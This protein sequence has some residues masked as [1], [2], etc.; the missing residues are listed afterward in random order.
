VY[1]DKDMGIN[2]REK[3]RQRICIIGAGIAGLSAAYDLS[4]WGYDVIILESLDEV[5][6]LASSLDVDG[7][8]IERFYHFISKY[9]REL[10]AFVQELELADKL[11]WEQCKTS[12]FYNGKLYRFNTP[13]DLLR[14]TPIPFDQRIRFGL[15]IIQ[16][17]FRR[18]WLTLDKLSAK[19]WLT[20]KVGQRAYDVIWDP[21]LR[22]KFGKYHE[23]VSAAWIWH[24][25]H[26]VATSRRRIWESEVFGYLD[27]GSETLIRTLV[28]CVQKLP[29]VELRINADVCRILTKN[30]HVAGVELTENKE[31][32][33]CDYVISTVALPKL[34][35]LIPKNDT[36]YWRRIQKIDY[37][38]VVCGLLVLSQPL[39]D[40]F[41]TN[42]H[43]PNIAFNGIIEH[44]NLNKSVN[45]SGNSI[46]Y[47]PHYLH[48]SEPR[49][50]YSDGD[51]LEE[52]VDGLS[53]VNP[54]FNRSWIK[55]YHISRAE[56]AQ[57]I[58]TV[59]FADVVP[60]HET[61]IG[62]LYIT[63]ST[64]YYPED[65]TISAAIRLGRTVSSMI[66]S[67]ANLNNQPR[68]ILQR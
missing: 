62:G 15:N 50:R 38:G 61:D 51:L 13:F 19:S 29:N 35:G 41:W 22:I 44:T 45:V 47:V 59:S 52:F 63:D 20:D 24:R 34:H 1:L 39:T 6:G 67:E 8:P 57:A 9:D 26:R 3:Q 56:H 31:G 36:S 23:Q 21:L 7:K 16:S 37:L 42:I 58:C 10:I 68:I 4:R 25:I 54:K 28:N 32:I 66:K 49:Y 60:S 27:G 30:D 18:S 33:P 40:N 53:Q 55:E 17:R 48:T 46:V 12:F 14:F 2:S 11:H 5:G 64:Q 65:R 43:D